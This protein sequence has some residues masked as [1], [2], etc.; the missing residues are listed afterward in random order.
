MFCVSVTAETLSHYHL[1]YVN[2]AVNIK[3]VR[4]T[5]HFCNSTA[6]GVN[7]ALAKK[8]HGKNKNMRFLEF[9]QRK[10]I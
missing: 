3:S 1:L 6:L 10:L 2:P 7:T 4:A 8:L 9:R 5:V